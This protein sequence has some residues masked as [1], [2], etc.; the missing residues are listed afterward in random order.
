MSSMEDGSEN[1]TQQVMAND[2]VVTKRF[3][4][5]KEE[6]LKSRLDTLKTTFNTLQQSNPEIIGLTIYGSMATGGAKETSDIDGFVFLEEGKTKEHIT[7]EDYHWAEEESQQ[8]EKTKPEW[9]TSRGVSDIDL[10]ATHRYRP[11]VH[12]TLKAKGL[13]EEQIKHIRI[14]VVSD[15]I[16]RDELEKTLES[17]R[18]FIKYKED[19]AT[20]DN[21]LDELPFDQWPSW[22]EKP[23]FPDQYIVDWKIPA[24][25][26]LEI[27]RGLTHY[28]SEVVK[29]L[30]EAGEVGE[31]V[32]QHVIGNTADME[33][34]MRGSNYPHLY[35]TTLD[36]ALNYYHIETENN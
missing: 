27:G 34:H 2:E 24:M 6:Q 8:Y 10:A 11:I 14:R 26:H 15:E 1:N 30:R 13:T 36:E 19:M 22:D 12:E 4:L 20:W 33:R 29:Q 23:K 9:S 31:R 25:F 28:R 16:I 7:E 35:P 32:W 5:P 3:N 21:K 18:K 17:E